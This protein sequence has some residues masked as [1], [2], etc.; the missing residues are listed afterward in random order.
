MRRYRR[1]ASGAKTTVIAMLLAMECQAGAATGPPS[2]RPRLA[3]GSAVTGLILTH[4]CSQPGKV[5]V[6]TNTLLPN[7]SGN[8]TM[9]PNPCKLC[10]DLTYRPRSTQIQPTAKP[11]TNISPTAPSADSGLAAIRNPSSDPYAKTIATET[12]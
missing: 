1:T 12:R 10:G 3:L 6:W 4:A 5:L 7:V 11:K 8:I 9:N 2:A